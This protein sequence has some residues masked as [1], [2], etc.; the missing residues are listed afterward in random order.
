MRK[1]RRQNLI[2]GSATCPKACLFGEPIVV[3]V[4]SL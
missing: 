1:L 3:G 4:G 2:K